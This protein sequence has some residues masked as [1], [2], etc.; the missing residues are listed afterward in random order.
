MLRCTDREEC[1]SKAV[2]AIVSL[3]ID[4][5][6]VEQSCSFPDLVMIQSLD[7]ALNETPARSSSFLTYHK[8]SSTDV[9]ASVS[10]YHFVEVFALN[11]QYFSPW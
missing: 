2:F 8:Q 11:R 3:L 9:E 4:T 6:E 1:N 7:R 5:C 10:S